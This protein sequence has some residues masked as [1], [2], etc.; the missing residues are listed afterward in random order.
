MHVWLEPYTKYG[1]QMV[2]IS[3]L[4]G[5]IEVTYVVGDLSYGCYMTLDRDEGVLTPIAPQANPF[6]IE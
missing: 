3:N 2:T 6:P 1:I 4:I 5:T